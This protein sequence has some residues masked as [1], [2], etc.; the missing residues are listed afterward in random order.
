MK[1][2]HHFAA[3]ILV[4]VLVSGSI[5]GAGPEETSPSASGAGGLLLVSLRP[6][7]AAQGA[8]VVLKDVATFR[9]GSP[10]LL[11]RIAD[12]DLIDAPSAG[13]TTTISKEAIAFR[14][15][16]A[17][18]D[19][20]AF[21]L[22]GADQV[23]VRSPGLRLTEEDFV[24]AAR[25]HLLHHLPWPADDVRI[26]VIQP[27]HVPALDL[28]RGDQVSLEA[29]LH[30][31]GNM[32]GRV[33]VD[34]A[35][36]VNGRQRAVVPVG[37]DIKLHQQLALAARRIEAGEVL[38]KENLRPDRRV[39]GV[40]NPYLTFADCAAGKRAKR[41]IPAGQLLAPV[42]VEMKAATKFL[43]KQHDLVKLMAKVGSM[44][45]TALGEALQDGGA[46]Q[47]IRVKNV[48]SK[49]VIL[50]RVVDRSLVEVDY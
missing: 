17:G 12:L 22:E 8:C 45:V 27:P 7:V 50:G 47:F 46:G 6:T 28:G 20:R 23:V 30:S 41:A 38:S 44:R 35:V 14:L 26:Q 19:R 49:N 4:C 9:G 11:Q 5:R 39:V 42:D 32:V 24:A 2:A 21:H 40:A 10:T 18:I 3:W 34:I 29:E 16:L 25:K 1:P 36:L 31:S 37:L 43:V 13:Q 33:L 48:D 15:Q